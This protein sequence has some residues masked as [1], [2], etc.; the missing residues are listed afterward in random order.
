MKE[1]LIDYLEDDVYQVKKW[2]FAKQ[3]EETDGWGVVFQGPLSECD[4]YIRLKC[5]ESVDF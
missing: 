1:Y 4:A 5:N 2:F 3:Y